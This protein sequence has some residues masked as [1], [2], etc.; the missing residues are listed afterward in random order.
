ML[1]KINVKKEQKKLY[2]IE[3]FDL[4]VVLDLIYLFSNLFSFNEDDQ[5]SISK[6]QKKKLSNLY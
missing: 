4:Y 3:F 1:L 5:S 2:I 6:K